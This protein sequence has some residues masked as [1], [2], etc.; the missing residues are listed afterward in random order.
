MPTDEVSEDPFHVC[1]TVFAGA[2]PD[3]SKSMILLLYGIQKL[4]EDDSETIACQQTSN[5]FDL[6]WNCENSCGVGGGPCV[7]TSKSIP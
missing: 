6:I 7:E 4:D 5:R 1:V 3:Y 2:D